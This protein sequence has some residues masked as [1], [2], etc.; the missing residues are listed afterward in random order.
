LRGPRRTTPARDLATLRGSPQAGRA[1]QGADRCLAINRSHIGFKPRNF[2]AVLTLALAAW[3][4]TPRPASAQVKFAPDQCAAAL[5]IAEEIEDS[6]DISPRLKASFER[7]RRS[8]CDV[9]TRFERDTEVDVKAFLE[10]RL[11]F[12]MW[13]T[14]NDNPIRRGCQPQ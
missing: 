8:R 4:L 10:F 14:C 12:E 11:K 6:F 7:F 13:R 2:G 1:A 5:S 9:D 3:A